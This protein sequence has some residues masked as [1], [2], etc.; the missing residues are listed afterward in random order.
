MARRGLGSLSTRSAGILPGSKHYYRRVYTVPGWDAFLRLWSY[1]LLAQACCGAS[2]QGT[3]RVDHDPT[4]PGV[5]V[6]ADAF[7]LPLQDQSVDTV[8]CDPIYSMGFDDRVRLQREL[9]R[10]ARW[11]VLFKGPW[12]PRVRGFR[13]GGVFLL[14][15]HTSQNVAVLSILNRQGLNGS[16]LP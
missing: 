4:A 6:V 7:H 14:A 13:L 9:A 3:I 12:I 2:R 15:S 5:N 11:R 16:V 1:G 8:A 10:V